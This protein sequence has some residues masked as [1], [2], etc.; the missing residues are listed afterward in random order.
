MSV[1]VQGKP[2]S[3]AIPHSAATVRLVCMVSRAVRPERFGVSDP[4]RAAMFPCV[5]FFLVLSG[6]LLASPLVVD[7]PDQSKVSALLSAAWGGGAYLG[8]AAACWSLAHEGIT[9]SEDGVAAR[10]FLR[11]IHWNWP[12]IDG[13][14]LGSAFD[15][16]TGTRWWPQLLLVSGE[17]AD[18]RVCTSL[19]REDD[20]AAA[21]AVDAIRRGLRNHR[22]TTNVQ[23][24]G[25]RAAEI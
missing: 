13:V 6:C 20:S 7:E 12:Q 14:A 19:T 8:L 3:R 16:D 24:D 10:M 15:D 23:L 4:F 2:C 18:L 25:G 17:V 5:A 9:V 1:P 11:T 21:H 22:H